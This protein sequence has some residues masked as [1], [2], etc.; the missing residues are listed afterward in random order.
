MYACH[1]YLTVRLL[2]AQN[3]LHEQ[4]VDLALD[5]GEVEPLHALAGNRDEL[6]AGREGIDFCRG[7]LFWFV[8]GIEGTRE[9][10]SRSGASS[11]TARKQLQQ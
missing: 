9:T 5:G 8:H 2:A 4:L 11:H 7:R 3:L 1:A 6:V 10:R